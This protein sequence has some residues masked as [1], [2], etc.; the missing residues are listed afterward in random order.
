MTMASKS[1][2]FADYRYYGIGDR[3]GSVL[4]SDG[5]GLEASLH[6]GGPLHVVSSRADQIFKDLS[7]SDTS[8]L[9]HYKGDLLLTYHSS[10]SA[11]SQAE[12]KRWNHENEKLADATERASVA[13]DWL[14]ALPYDKARITDAWWKFLPGQ[15]HDL[16]AGT[17]LP[18]SYEFAW[19]DQVLALNEFAD[20]LH[21]AVGGVTRG[22]DTTG[23]GVPVVVYNPLSAKR[24]DVVTAS[25][26]FPGAAPSAVQV[27]GPDGAVVPSQIQ[28]RSG[29]TMNL[30][31]LA[32]VP[33]VGSAVYHVRPAAQS[34]SAG[35]AG[36]KVTTDSLENARF[37]V[38]ID[39]NGDVA[40][41]YDKK[42]GREMLSAPMRLAFQYENPGEY[43]AWNMDYEDQRKPAEGYVDG[44][45]KI[46]VVENGPARVAV[47]ID[48]W[49]RGSHFVQT[50]RLASGQ[51][52]DRVELLENI[53]WQT[54]E[55]ALKAVMPLTVSN[56]DGDLQLGTRHDPAFHQQPPE[57]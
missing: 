21:Q 38:K 22:L 47:Q 31:F 54:K 10:G 20:V 15:F 11:T 28:S 26:S 8:K 44:P 7:L 24:Q 18:K 9:P 57:V 52:G 12:M 2:I 43:P 36:L 16:M 34:G 17:A 48:R 33:S 35:A 42:A 14:G 3:G 41:I 27:I 50:V 49:A 46:A 29:G 37:R 56:P 55:A 45:A 53:D 13:A 5:A 23:A 32:S 4:D 1:G 19:N 40:S 39:A 51:A 6:G 30:L 25:V